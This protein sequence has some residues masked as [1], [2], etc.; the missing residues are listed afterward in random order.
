MICTTKKKGGVMQKEEKLL[1]E[2]CV[3][4]AKGEI[5]GIRFNRLLLESGIY[6]DE[7]EWHEANRLLSKSDQF[8]CS[9]E[10]PAQ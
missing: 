1:R 5:G 3:E 8:P 2:L 7:D 6:L 9:T 4:I 10:L